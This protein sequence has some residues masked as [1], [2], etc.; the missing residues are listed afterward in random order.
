MH[1]R[2]PAVL[3][4]LLGASAAFAQV[5]PGGAPSP[6]APP[7]STPT[8][9]FAPSGGGSPGI[10]VAGTSTAPP[11]RPPARVMVDDAVQALRGTTARGSDAFASDY[12]GTTYLFASAA[13]KADFDR[14]PTTY[15][16]VG[17]G[18]CGRTGALGGMGDARRWAVVEGK[19]Y[20]FDSEDC[21]KLFKLDPK[22]FIEEEDPTPLGDPAA[23]AAGLEAIDRWIAWSGGADA[24]R[25]AKRV[26][27]TVTRTVEQWGGTWNV[28]ESI[29]LAWPGTVHRVETWE[30][31]PAKDAAMPQGKP[32]TYR[33]EVVTSPTISATSSTMQPPTPLMG[34][35]KRA[36][37]R[38]AARLPMSIMR[39][40]LTPEA[41]FVAVRIGNGKVGAAECDFVATRSDGFTTWLAIEKE[42]GRL[43]QIGYTGRDPQARVK[44]LTL[45]VVSYAGPEQL[46]L[47]TQWITAVTGETEGWKSP[48]ATISVE[49]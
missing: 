8:P 32:E 3:T 5:V 44:P 36:V 2:L 47:P 25:A 29:E 21:M 9:N 27:Q 26:T 31:L 35:R 16:A 46:K 17:G 23:Q 10:G 14:A 48:V 22:R 34:S 11:A 40:R 38:L 30:R 4:V 13:N 18:T 45:D 19:L 37:E 7:S 20:F 12:E 43:A 15:A 1:P 28:T 42:T 41:G 33:Y 49:K 39:A 24:V 6:A